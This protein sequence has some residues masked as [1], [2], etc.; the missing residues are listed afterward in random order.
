MNQNISPPNQNAGHFIDRTS[1][2]RREK[3]LEILTS[4]RHLR[5]VAGK[6]KRHAAIVALLQILDPESEA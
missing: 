5:K 1:R 4:P 6:A 3:L 2:E